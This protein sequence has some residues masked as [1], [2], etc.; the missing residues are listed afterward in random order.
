MYG[1]TRK[2]RKNIT[3]ENTLLIK[4]GLCNNMYMIMNVRGKTVLHKNKFQ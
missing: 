2:D 3:K 1:Q 4:L